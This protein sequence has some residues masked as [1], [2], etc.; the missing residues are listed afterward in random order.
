M[1][2]YIV[3]D[4]CICPQHHILK[5]NTAQGALIMLHCKHTIQPVKDSAAMV[6]KN[7]SW[8]SKEISWLQTLKRNPTKEH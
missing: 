1:F 4:G 5:L 3:I 2:P 7:T 8:Q 6:S